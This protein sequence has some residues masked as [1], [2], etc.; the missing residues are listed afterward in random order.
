MP[1]FGLLGICMVIVD[2][3]LETWTLVVLKWCICY[4]IA[5]ELSLVAS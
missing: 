2:I 5:R 4:I 1:V 3:L